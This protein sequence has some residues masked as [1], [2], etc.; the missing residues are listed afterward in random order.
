[1]VQPRRPRRTEVVPPPHLFT[2]SPYTGT[3]TGGHSPKIC[4]TLPPT[5]LWLTLTISQLLQSHYSVLHSYVLLLLDDDT[6]SLAYIVDERAGVAMMGI[7]AVEGIPHRARRR[8]LGRD[9]MCRQRLAAQEGLLLRPAY[10]AAGLLTRF[11]R[12]PKKSRD[13]R[14][15]LQTGGMKCCSSRY[16][17]GKASS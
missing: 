2:Q 10:S 17:I 14:G 4:P 13:G 12:R 1:M 8:V 11:L 16:V 9:H 7:Q 15:G 5:S 3:A 6:R